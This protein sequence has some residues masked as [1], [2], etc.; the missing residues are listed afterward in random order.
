VLEVIPRRL[1]ENGGF[2]ANYILNKLRQ[3]YAQGGSWFG[4][5]SLSEERMQQTL[6]LSVCGNQLWAR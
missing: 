5:D 3:K 6:L 1:S 4:V 2:D